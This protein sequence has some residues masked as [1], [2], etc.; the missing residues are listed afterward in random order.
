MV[1]R[2][3]D[4]AIQSV[5]G[6]PGS[7]DIALSGALAG[8]QT[9]QQAGINAGDTFSYLIVDGLN[10]EF[11]IGTYSSVGLNGT[12]QRTTIT[13][14]SAQ[15]QTPISVSSRANVSAILRG[16]DV[17]PPAP[18][19]L[20]GLADVNI[21]EGAGINE[22]ALTWDEPSQKWIAALP[23][24]LVTPA[25]IGALASINNLGDVNNASFSRIN[26]GLGSMATQASSAVAIT[27]GTITGVTLPAADLTGTLQ[28]AQEPAHT[29]DVTN[30]A[31]SLAMALA[32]VNAG[33]G[34]VGSS[35]AIPVLTTNAKGLVTAQ[36]TAAVV[37]PAGTLTGTTLASNVV[38]SSLTSVGTLAAG[39]VPT[40]LL[41]GTLQAAQEPAHTGD[42][43]NTAGS[44]AMALATVNAGSGSVGS[45]TAIPVLTTNAKGLVTAQSTAAVVAPAG[46]L[47]G[48]TLASN[49]VTS[50]LTSVGTLAAGAVPTTL[51][52]GTLQA[53]QEPAHTGDVT[54]TAGSLATTVGSIGG[55]AVSLGGSL[56]ISGVFGTTFTIT[57]TTSV[58]LPTSGTLA[59]VAG[60]AQV[61]NNLSDL[62]NEATARTNL[63]LGT[64]ATQASSAVAITGG[65]I[66][67]AINAGS[68]LLSSCSW[69]VMA[70][71]LQ[72]TAL[73]AT[74]A[75]TSA[76][77]ATLPGGATW[78]GGVFGPDGNIYGIPVYATTILKINPV[79]GVATTSAMGATLPG[80]A[81]WVGGVLGPDGNIYGIP[82]AAT[83]ILKINPVTGV[84]TTSAMGATL[85]GG[86]AWY[87][88]VLGPDGNIYG[89]PNSATTIL[90]INPVTGVATT[91]AM[92][93]TLPGGVAW[94][95]GVLGPDGNIYGIP[96]T[97]TTILKINPITGVA[98]TSNM[99]A[100]LPGGGAW[101][102]GVLGPDGNI[103]GIPCNATTILKINP[104][105]GVA[106]TSNMG[107]TL[108]GS[109]AW[110]G[111]V[112]GP[113][114]NI[115]GIPYDATTILK[116]N[117]ITGVATTSAMG[118]TLPGGNAWVGGILGPDGNIYGIPYNATTILKIAGNGSLTLSAAL[119]GFL[120]K[121]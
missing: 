55:K 21:S 39:A 3:L 98:T 40:T 119:S 44:L 46:T 79:T 72:P 102:G 90:K 117:P 99:G 95:G 11:G 23:A 59:T 43:T 8:Y 52:T 91:S 80:G 63:G 24:S 14:T 83:T 68:G 88:G 84:A 67:G 114:G 58:T 64:M 93:A 82:Y 29:G 66:S 17:P 42:V 15:N 20:A 76:M 111:G 86:G 113:D 9:F 49:V 120:N 10:W 115:Y 101:V 31:G 61:A 77:G 25:S 104:I 7:G 74:A 65:T 19:T 36:S 70:G 109:G 69:T 22:Y 100:T 34:S 89:I 37:A 13:N 116:I 33:S 56:T 97:A 103:Y 28:A 121:L 16:E 108:P 73:P 87:G 35:T 106:T 75:T 57:A 81:A 62:A 85:P 38:T 107:A 71:L 110:F 45:S 5:S 26:L 53:A 41:T 4:R 48:T 30:T 6:T 32:T 105:T 60:S 1:F 112:L 96:Y 94:I 78:Q 118:A 92:G 12:V 18:T 2:Y 51:L 54:N 50:S 47:T 27:G